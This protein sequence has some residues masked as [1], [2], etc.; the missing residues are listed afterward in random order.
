MKE[1]YET[2]GSTTPGVKWTGGK[3]LAI[4]AISTTSFN[5]GVVC[6]CS[7][8]QAGISEGSGEY[9]GACG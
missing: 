3:W 2:H 7:I 9:T 6:G 8:A 1:E 4:N 5:L